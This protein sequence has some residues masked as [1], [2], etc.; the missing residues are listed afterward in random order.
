MKKTI[1]LT[2]LLLFVSLLSDSFMK[3][4]A[5]ASE[6]TLRTLTST[7]SHV[8]T[9]EENDSTKQ[10]IS[11]ISN[12]IK[13][14]KKVENQILYK[15]VKGTVYHAV[16]EQTDSTPLITADLSVIDT[17]KVN[18]LRWVALSR[19]LLNRRYTDPKGKKHF[20][21]GKIKLGDTIWVDYD[22]KNLWELTHKNHNPKDTLAVKRNDAKYQKMKE[23]YEQVKGYWIVHDVMGTQYTRRTRKGDYI[24]DKNGNKQIVKIYNA[25]DF[26]QHPKIGMNDVWNRNLIISKRTVTY[27]TS[28]SIALASN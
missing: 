27:I 19:D 8:I 18:E 1:I 6:A 4:T 3:T 10:L 13:L 24:L 25:I 16:S 21:N 11:F 22:D 26:L 7:M 28:N 5:K 9:N 23:K 12:E 14:V 17:T 20:W 2:C 15:Q